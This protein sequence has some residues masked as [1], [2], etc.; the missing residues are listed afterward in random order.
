MQTAE[1]IREASLED[2]EAIA[3]VHV[4]TWQAA[5][6]GIVPDEYLDSLDV[7][8]RTARWRQ[9][10]AAPGGPT[11]VAEIEGRVVGWANAGPSRDEDDQAAPGELYGIYVEAASWGHGPGRH[12]ME[13]ATAWLR[14]RYPEAT[15]WT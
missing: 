8:D 2:A 5:Y 11:W 6:R 9:G 1:V 4:A 13:E 12:L 3:R 14:P 15:L 7:T 10:L